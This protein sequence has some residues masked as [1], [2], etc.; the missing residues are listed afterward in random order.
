MVHRNNFNVPGWNDYVQDKYDILRKAFLNW[1]SCDGPRICA[2]FSSM[3]RSR[4]S[5]KLVLRYCRQHDDQLQADACAKAL[6]SNDAKQFWNNVKKINSNKATKYA[7]C[8]GGV[9]GEENIASMWRKYFHDLYNSV[10]DDG[11]RCKLLARLDARNDTQYKSLISLQETSRAV[12]TQKKGKATGPEGIAM[13]AFM[14]GNTRL[15]VHLNILFNMFTT[16]CH[17]P[18]LFMQSYIVP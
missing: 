14:C 4:A 17:T 15:L 1:V 18:T 2:I 5:F 11:S 3:S 8:V 16:H 10:V 7:M 13:E 6:D 12:L 9:S